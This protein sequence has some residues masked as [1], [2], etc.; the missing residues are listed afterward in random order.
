[1]SSTEL[2]RKIRET[3]GAAAKA[4][5]EGQRGC[6]A[7]GPKQTASG[8][9]AAASGASPAG[10]AKQTAS[11]ASSKAT[12]GDDCGCGCGCDSLIDTA[13]I[14]DV[15][16]RLYNDAELATLPHAAALASLGCGNPTAVAELRLGEVVLDLGS[17]GGI[18]VLLSARRVGPEGRAIGLDST[19]E[20]IQLARANLEA[21]GAKNAE[22]LEG[23]IEA[24]PLPENSVDVIIS[25]CVVNLAF[26]KRRVFA[27][28]MRVLQP[29]G[30]LAISD[31]VFEVEPGAAI[32]ND[33]DSYAACV[34]G[35]LTVDE[36]SRVLDEVGFRE[37][38]I[39]P[40]RKTLL[41]DGTTTLLSALIRAQKPGVPRDPAA[42]SGA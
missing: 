4:A 26:D 9:I 16:E 40:T 20:M 32:R 31:M 18:D 38:S 35:A 19:P 21:A 25:N 22:I 33:A 12:S 13:A 15:S 37:V 3:Y 27:E 8:E 28:S 39:E 6:C 1:M 2:A 23:T 17:G 29:G 34:S 41:A 36:L 24:I 14:A 30:R 42:R 5:A 7:T 11:M 10:S